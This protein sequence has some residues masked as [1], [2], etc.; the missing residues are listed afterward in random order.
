MLPYTNP[1]WFPVSYYK[2]IYLKWF[3]VINKLD[4]VFTI[5]K[6][7]KSKLIRKFKLKKTSHIKPIMLG[8][9]F[10]KKRKSLKVAN[11]LNKEKEVPDRVTG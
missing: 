8:A 5:S 6:T 3:N 7:V 4:Y 11:N 2:K 9:N 1:E 10:A